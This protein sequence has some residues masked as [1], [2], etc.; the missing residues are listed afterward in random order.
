MKNDIKE[1]I[2]KRVDYIRNEMNITKEEFSKLIN[3]SG[4]HLGKVIRGEKGLSIEKIIE[5]SEKTG[6][7]TEYILKGVTN[8]KEIYSPKI[9]EIKS[10]IKI[11]N[12][13]IENILW[14]II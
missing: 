5:V 6:Y 8:T 10:H 7:S 9:N 2:G 12:E 13:I 3:I 4:Q 14:V 11:I 1:Q